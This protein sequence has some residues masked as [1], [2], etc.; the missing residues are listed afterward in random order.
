[1]F[2]EL[3]LNFLSAHKSLL[4]CLSV[5]LDGSQTPVKGAFEAVGY[6]RRKKAKTTNQ[7]FLCDKNGIVISFGRAVAG[8]HH[9]VFEIKK[10]FEAMLEKL[11]LL[12][13]RLDALIC[14]ADDAFDCQELRVICRKYG[15]E[16]NFRFNAKNGALSEREEYFDE[17]FFK[18]RF[19]IERSFDW[20]DAFKALLI[21]FEKKVDHW[22]SLIVIALLVINIKKFSLKNVR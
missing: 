16:C 1:M 17:Q 12:G 20:M 18:D 19:V 7:L 13:I 14:N 8:N 2:S 3:W 9:D 6:Q 21:R 15:I 11:V 5:Q 4:N 10:A 22:M